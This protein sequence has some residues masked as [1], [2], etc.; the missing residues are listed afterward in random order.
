MAIST[1]NIIVIG[2][3]IRPGF[4][5]WMRRVRSRFC[6]G[7]LGGINWPDSSGKYHP[8][9]K[10]ESDLDLVEDLPLWRNYAASSMPKIRLK[11]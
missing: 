2:M 4:C 8:G 6:H 7:K 11:I 5:A 1:D 3:A 10:S 9:D